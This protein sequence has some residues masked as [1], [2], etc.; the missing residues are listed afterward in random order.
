MS[1]SRFTWHKDFLLSTKWAEGSI[2]YLQKL[3][4]QVRVACTKNFWPS[5]KMKLC[6][7][8]WGKTAPQQT[9]S[10][11]SLFN[12]LLVKCINAIQQFTYF[13]LRFTKRFF[14]LL[15]NTIRFCQL[16]TSD[17]V[18]DFDGTSNLFRISGSE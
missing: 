12:I 3:K 6:F 18:L 8:K 5:L 16:T 10:V 14:V 1:R 11:F 7:F 13:S 15:I 9:F 4:K 2:L 17:R